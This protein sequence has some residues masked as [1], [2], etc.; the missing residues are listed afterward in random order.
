MEQALLMWAPDLIPLLKPVWL[1]DKYFE[2]LDANVDDL[3]RFESQGTSDVVKW[4]GLTRACRL[5]A[6][7]GPQAIVKP[8]KSSCRLF[9][10]LAE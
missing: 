5:Y 1:G 10:S 8:S 6:E 7:L 3:T 4:L 9:A 2:R